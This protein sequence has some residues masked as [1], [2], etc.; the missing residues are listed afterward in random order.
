MCATFTAESL[1]NVGQYVIPYP[2]LYFR[3][4]FFF[5]LFDAAGMGDP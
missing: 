1:S 3:V 2:V 5:H 4:F